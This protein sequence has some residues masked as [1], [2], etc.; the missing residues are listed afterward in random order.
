MLDARAEEKSHEIR[1][2]SYSTP[3][4]RKRKRRLKNGSPT[5][6]RAVARPIDFNLQLK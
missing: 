3:P 5:R 1:S 4:D 6:H 2:I